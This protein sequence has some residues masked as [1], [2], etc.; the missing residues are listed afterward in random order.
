MTDMLVAQRHEL[1]VGELE[2]SGVLKITE[3]ADRLRV[4]RATI[5]RDLMDL[6]A[7]GRV[8]R[9]R[10]GALLS[11]PKPGTP[12][13][14]QPASRQLPSSSGQ[15]GG[16]APELSL[17]LMVPS[18]TYY[19]PRAVAG[20]R[21]V[22]AER[23][24]RVMIG[25]TDYAQARDQEQIEELAAAGA[26]G[27]LVATAGGHFLSPGTL[28][29]LRAGGLPF[30][31]MERQPENAFEPCEFVA[32]DHRQGAFAAVRH[33][34]GL[35][36]DRVALFT[37]GSPT[38]PL[39]AEGHAAA[40]EQLGLK[41]S[42]PT[43]DSG[44]PKQG[45]AE[46]ARHYDQFIKECLASRTRAALVHSDHDAIELIRRMRSAGLRTPDDLALIAYDD[47]IAALAEVP[48]TAVA[49]A[50]HEL[51][52]LAARLLLDRLQAPDPDEVPVRQL[53]VQPRLI[54]RASCGATAA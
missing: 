18:A 38:A 22:A 43:L 11:T 23:N 32:S 16:S 9:V 47:E 45:T 25:L 15:F 8:T 24:A 29:Q 26:H 46:A 3:L 7:E 53:L 13:G 33:L 5:R 30:V 10:G 1:L 44:R 34:V 6:E 2:K 17:G 54:V 42:A 52:E 36:H 41:P 31:L 51:G 20:V 50:K 49:P 28:E 39:L 37:N 35:G 19:Y 14:E 21:A 4:S 27:L 48:L 40:V 12:S